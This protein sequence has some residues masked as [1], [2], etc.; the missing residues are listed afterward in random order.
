MISHN[1]RVW[2]DRSFW[3]FWFFFFISTVAFVQL[4]L[5]AN[6]LVLG[7]AL[8][9]IAIAWLC[10]KLRGG[11]NYGSVTVFL[12]VTN[13]ITVA[14]FIKT[15]LLQDLDSNLY[16]PALSFLAIFIGSLEFFLALIVV[17]S[18]HIR[19]IFRPCYNTR[20][21][22]FI[23]LTTFAIGTVSWLL[24]QAYSHAISNY[25]TD[26]PGIGGFSIF[27]NLFIM[28]IVSLTASTILKSNFR[29]SANFLTVVTFLCA[30]VM[31]F[32]DNSKRQILMLFIAYLL[33]CYYFKKPFSAKQIVPC[34]LVLIVAVIFVFPVTQYLRALQIQKLDLSDKIYL[35]TDVI[36][37]T[38]FNRLIKDAQDAK[39]H[40]YSGGYYN[41]FGGGGRFQ[42]LGGRFAS[43]QQIDPVFDAANKSS[44]LGWGLIAHGFKSVIPRILYPEK[45]NRADG[46]IIATSLG[47]TGYGSGPYP[48]VPL[49]ACAYA[50]LGVPGLLFIPFLTFL[51]YLVVQRVVVWRVDYNI[52]AIFFL[53]QFF[54]Y[55]HEGS[56]QKYVGTI[57]R[58]IPTFVVIFI[59][60]GWIYK[61][62]F[63]PRIG[64]RM[65]T[66]KLST[67]P[68]PTTS[69]PTGVSRFFPSMR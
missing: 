12:F 50:A 38:E 10:I 44:Q 43:V 34:S 55:I 60:I 8:C 18:M 29:R 20:Y 66:G 69:P 24:N 5:G 17:D 54:N 56:F 41:Y 16:E 13:T 46:Y 37:D 68:Q 67:S 57:L 4:A 1:R 52:F 63:F 62:T 15:F 42:M 22:N 28:S 6:V 36:G 33:T 27:R 23:G 31:G 51:C 32:I 53:C 59:L 3:S 40:A 19:S 61:R 39:Q 64:K 21:L 48:T 30:G 7:I 26:D 35:A 9:T 14:I 11:G 49:L 45:D 58:D 47:L 25:A 2:F 65:I